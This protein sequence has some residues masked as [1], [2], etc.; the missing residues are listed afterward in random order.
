[1]LLVLQHI[2]QLQGYIQASVSPF[3][4]IGIFATALLTS[5]SGSIYP[6]WYASRIQPA[7]AL[8]YE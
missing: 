4:L 5:L 3:M 6:A 2:P 7:E 1:L 8:R